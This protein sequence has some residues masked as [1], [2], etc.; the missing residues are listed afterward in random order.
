[1]RPTSM[2]SIV[3]TPLLAAMA[4][5]T[6]CATTGA[7]NAGRG[8]TSHSVASYGRTR[9]SDDATRRN[10]AREYRNSARFGTPQ[11]RKFEDIIPV[12]SRIAA[13]HIAQD[14]AVTA[15]WLTYERSGRESQTP[16]RGGPGGE[17]QTFRLDRRE[18]I[19]GLHAYGRP[20]IQ[21]IQI[22]TN[23]RVVT[24]GAPVPANATSWYNE[25]TV[26]E[27]RRSVGVGLISRSNTAVRQLMLRSQV[28]QE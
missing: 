11:G 2:T 14:D 27:K 19:V 18:K 23:R 8:V 13:V 15:I 28:H 21:T 6:G 26:D 12:G 20:A 7:V 16:R 17:V 10:A 5:S 22:A 9:V 24:L 1:M 25:I 4:L 3:C